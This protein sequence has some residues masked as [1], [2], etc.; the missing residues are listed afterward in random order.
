MYHSLEV[1]MQ[2]VSRSNQGVRCSSVVRALSH[3]AMGRP[4]DPSW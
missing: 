4:I 1:A 2:N 3:G